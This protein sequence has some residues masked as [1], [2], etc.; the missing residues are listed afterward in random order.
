MV[1]ALPFRIFLA[2][3]GDLEHEREVVR[4]CVDEHNTRRSGHSSVT[5]EVVGWDR[6]RGTARRPQEAINELIS[7]SHFMVAMFK[8]T[9]GSEPGSP[10]GYSSGTEEELFTGLLELGRAEQP[11]RDVWTA[12]LKH[13]SPADPIVNLRKQMSSHHSV[14][15]EAVE[16]ARELRNKLTERLLTWE[17]VVNSSKIPRHIELL[18]SSGRDVLRAANLRLRGEKLIDLGQTEAGI[19]ALREATNLGGP[20][21]HLAYARFLARDGDFDAAYTSTQQA[22]DQ[23]LD[24]ASHLYSPL[25]AEAFAAQAGL[26]R[27]VGRYVDA[28]GRLRQALTLLDEND[29]FGQKIR[30]RILDELGLAYSKVDNPQLARRSFEDALAVRRR[31]GNEPDICQSLVNLARL[32][33]RAENLKMAA[34][35]AD[36]VIKTLCTMPPTALHANAEVLGAQVRLRQG[37]PNDGLPFGERALSLNRQLGNRRGEAIALKLLAQCYRSAGRRVEAESYAQACL[38]LNTSMHNTQGAQE[39]QWILD[40]LDE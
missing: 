21:E 30:C 25:A 31:T 8:G 39:A 29:A 9:W 38:E 14:M 32:E 3:P 37:R 34:D 11:M 36:E 12:F 15:Y 40:H 28:I 6:V 26:L 23:I 19:I 27:R 2:S 35:H 10:W 1:D 17:V 7:E 16:D 4:A 33:V 24:G 13:D 5:Y 20:G 22:I 18:P